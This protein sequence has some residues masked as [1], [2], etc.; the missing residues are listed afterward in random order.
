[1]FR[2][3]II[4]KQGDKYYHYAD[5]LKVATAY[6][7]ANFAIEDVGM[8]SVFQYEYDGNPRSDKGEL[9]WEENRWMRIYANASAVIPASGERSMSAN[10]NAQG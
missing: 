2:I 1:M 8:V 6:A 3:E 9:V 7:K 10:E 5:T 4:T